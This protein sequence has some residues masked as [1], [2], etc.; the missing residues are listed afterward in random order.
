MGQTIQT[1]LH[2]Y[3]QDKKLLDALVQT[4]QKEEQDAG[5][6]KPSRSEVI[7]Q[8]VTQECK[9]RNIS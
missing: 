7:R 3:P 5:R 4:I 1:V 6:K 8:L 2:L 9:K